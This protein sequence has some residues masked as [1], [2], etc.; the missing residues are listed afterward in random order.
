MEKYMWKDSVDGNMIHFAVKY[1]DDQ[2][3]IWFS[4]H[5]DAIWEMF[6]EE[7]RGLVDSLNRG[8]PQEIKNLDIKL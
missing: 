2:K 8:K 7:N 5:I 3:N 6:G 1:K 4:I